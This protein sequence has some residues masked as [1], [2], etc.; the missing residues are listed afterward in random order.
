MATKIGLLASFSNRWRDRL[1][2]C[3]LVPF[4]DVFTGRVPN[5][6]DY[7]FPYMSIITGGGFRVYR[8]DKF[9]GVL[10]PISI[11]I[12]TDPTN[13]ELGEEIAEMA[14]VIYANQAWVYDFGRVIDV[15]DGG[16][17]NCH[18]INDPTFQAWEVVKT[19][20]LCI[21]L[22]RVDLPLCEPAGSSS[23][24]SQAGSTSFSSLL[25]SKSSI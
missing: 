19:F 20:I 4:Q 14:R 8:S 18:Q 15:L 22:P 1:D 3:A 13:L 7:P 21:E 11:H 25:S 9:E 10:R 12:W 2:A 5:T 16:P 17:Q 6:V 24:L 23:S